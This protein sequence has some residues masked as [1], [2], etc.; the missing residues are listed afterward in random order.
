[1]SRR[2]IGSSIG[3]DRG[4]LQEL[5]VKGRRVPPFYGLPDCGSGGIVQLHKCIPHPEVGL[6]GADS[7][8]RSTP[9]DSLQLAKH[10]EGATG[11]TAK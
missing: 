9:G 7:A 4:T 3:Q 10:F 11:V 5:A 2:A 8:V 6:E 1:M